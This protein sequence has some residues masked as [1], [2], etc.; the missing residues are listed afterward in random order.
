MRHKWYKK[1]EQATHTDDWLMTYADMITLLLCFFAIFLSVSIPKKDTE[2]K[3]EVPKVVDQPTKHPDVLEGNLPFFGQTKAN[4]VTEH[5]ADQ[6]SPLEPV[7]RLPDMMPDIVDEIKAQAGEYMFAKDGPTGSPKAVD[8]TLGLNPKA[9]PTA[10]P[11]AAIIEAMKEA[12]PATIEQKGDRITTMQMNSAAFFTVG[13]AAVSDAGKAIL[14]QV[15]ANLKTAQYA[16]Y[17]ITVEGHTDDSPIKTLQF[18]SN[19]ELSTARA[20]AVVHFLLDQGIPAQKLRAAGYAD[21][22]PLVPN[23]DVT[24]TPIAGNQAQNRRVVIKLEKIDKPE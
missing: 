22:F 24:G 19:W 1:R 18:P 23:R 11:L 6:T 7:R 4:V 8:P 20:S 5:F 3:I 17:Q 15:A 12:G 9:D 13:S 2:K 16:N 21:T 14:V 10:I